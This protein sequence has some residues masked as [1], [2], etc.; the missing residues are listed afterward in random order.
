[1][2]RRERLKELLDDQRTM[3]LHTRNDIMKALT[4]PSEEGIDII[5]GHLSAL[6]IS[7]VSIA[8]LLEIQDVTPFEDIVK[9]AK[10]VSFLKSLYDSSPGTE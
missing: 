4:D 6:I 3:F 1:M 7:N 2:T 5:D 8:E 10:E 9:A